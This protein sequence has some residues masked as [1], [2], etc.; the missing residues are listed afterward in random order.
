MSSDYKHI[1][2]RPFKVSVTIKKN[3]SWPLHAVHP[4]H[5]PTPGPSWCLASSVFPACPLLSC[6]S[7]Q[8]PFH[9]SLPPPPP[10]SAELSAARVSPWMKRAA[11]SP[12]PG[13]WQLLPPTSTACTALD[14]PSQSPPR[15]WSVL[16]GGDGN[17]PGERFQSHDWAS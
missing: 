2:R 12:P 5:P 11:L 4:I 9:W 10:D 14:A 8:I 1:K 15:D 17:R 6:R 16:S 7:A 13:R 3:S